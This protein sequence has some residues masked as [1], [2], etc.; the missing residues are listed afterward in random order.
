MKK[1]SF[2]FPVNCQ[3]SSWGKWSS[4]SKTCGGNGIKH[5]S[6]RIVKNAKHGGKKCVGIIREKISCNKKGCPGKI[7][8]NYFKIWCLKYYLPLN[9]KK[10][11][12]NAGFPLFL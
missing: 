5:R 1:F 9:I 11:I 3:W 6:R 8:Q 10:K 2:I 4:C 7:Y 12:Y